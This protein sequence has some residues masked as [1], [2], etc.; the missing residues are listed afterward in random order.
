MMSCTSCNKFYKKH[1][2]CRLKEPM[3]RWCCTYVHALRWWMHSSFGMTSLLKKKQKIKLFYGGWGQ[4][5]MECKKSIIWYESS[6]VT[7]TA[8]YWFHLFLSMWW[9]KKEFYWIADGT[10]VK[11][12]S[13]NGF[14]VKK[15]EIMNF[16]RYFD[17]FVINLRWKINI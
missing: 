1:F 3:A 4:F 6:D 5:I 13:V 9:Y 11:F 17:P 8:V 7:K 15:N 16:W 12:N 10:V 14:E 2:H